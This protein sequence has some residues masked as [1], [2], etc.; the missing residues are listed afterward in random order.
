MHRF[1]GG[2]GN[3]NR[4]AIEL[5]SARWVA[6]QRN[7]LASLLCFTVLFG[8][9]HLAVAES[10]SF[11]SIDVPF[12]GVTGTGAYGVNPRGEI[13]GL[14]SDAGGEHGFLDDNGVF[15]PI[16]VPLS[17]GA[18]RTYALGINS[19]GQ[20]VGLY[21]D[22]SQGTQHGFLYDKGMFTD[23]TVPFTG[24]TNTAAEGISSSGQVVGGYTD[25]SGTHGFLEDGVA[26]SR[27]S[28]LHSP[29]S[30]LQR[31]KE[32]TLRDKS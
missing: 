9:S 2:S 3:S 6:T 28:T 31:L 13:V 10:F 32:L 27:R 4:N 24:V 7:F 18:T 22:F 5:R 26:C 17:G 30:P 16:I 19:Q 29:A 21:G 20:I 14:Y 15:T 1:A 8:S 12:S 11:T 23:I 25:G